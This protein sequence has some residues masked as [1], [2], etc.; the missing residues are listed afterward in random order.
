M[1]A[2]GRG[3][4]GVNDLLPPHERV[5]GK[6]RPGPSAA[7]PLAPARSQH[8]ARH[9]LLGIT[10]LVSVDPQTRMSATARRR[11]Q[12]CWRR[13]TACPALPSPSCWTRGPSALA[14]AAP[15]AAAGPVLRPGC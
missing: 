11:P 15:A 8:R 4:K 3:A 9:T 5:F 14:C 13:L 10:T 2:M 12:S 7:Q 6:T 1:R